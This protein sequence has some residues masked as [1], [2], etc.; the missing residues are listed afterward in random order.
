MPSWQEP[1][2]SEDE[3]SQEALEGGRAKGFAGLE[4]MDLAKVVASSPASYEWR[5]RKLGD[6]AGILGRDMDT[7]FHVVAYDFGVKKNILRM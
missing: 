5:G 2:L 6:R 4:G 1:D 7:E 3:S